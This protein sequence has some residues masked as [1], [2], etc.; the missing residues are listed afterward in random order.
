[1][2][3]L[4]SFLAAVLIAVWIGVI[5]IVSVQNFTAVSFK[6]LQFQSIQMPFGLVLAFSVGLGAISTALIQ[7]L[8]SSS[9]SRDFEED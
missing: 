7:L 5:A 2:K 1:M 8:S 6:F 3:T 4:P 9:R